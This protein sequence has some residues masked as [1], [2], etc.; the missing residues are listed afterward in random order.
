METMVTMMVRRMVIAVAVI[1]PTTTIAGAASAGAVFVVSTGARFWGCSA[2]TMLLVGCHGSALGRN[3]YVVDGR[4]FAGVVL[5]LAASKLLMVP[6][7]T[8]GCNGSASWRS[9]DEAMTEDATHMHGGQGRDNGRR[10]RGGRG[11]G[12]GCR[13]R[14]G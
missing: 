10:V 2:G 8:V 12:G 11:R 5:G 14:G 1:F 7:P 9:V 4:A 13:V 6:L 3:L